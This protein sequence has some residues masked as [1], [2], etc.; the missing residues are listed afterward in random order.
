MVATAAGSGD[1]GLNAS[2]PRGAALNTIDP[3][4]GS[5][6]LVEPTLRGVMMLLPRRLR[7]VGSLPRTPSG[8]VGNVKCPAARGDPPITHNE[9]ATSF[10]V[11]NEGGFVGATLV[12]PGADSLR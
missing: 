4:T 1:N 6:L 12:L 9:D 8:S 5:L 11:S 3:S 2:D 10:A 7:G